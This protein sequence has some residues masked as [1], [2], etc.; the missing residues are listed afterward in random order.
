V[1]DPV[2]YLDLEGFKGLTVMPEADV[3]ALE[4]KSQGFIA[5]RLALNSARINMR[6]RKRYAVPFQQ[7]YPQAVIAWL[8]AIVTP[9]AYERRGWNTSDEQADAIR[10]DR[11]TAIEELKEA[12]DSET[13]LF[14]LPLR[15]DTTEDG[16]TRGGPLGYSESDPYAWTDVQAEA[17]DERW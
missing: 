5:K 6:L 16:I 4:A 3:T 1:A 8:V 12:A 11:K 14:D 2:S 17:S 9:E 15:E 10:E 13:G 7:P